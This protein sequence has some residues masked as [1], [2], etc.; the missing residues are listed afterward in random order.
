LKGFNQQ[1]CNANNFTHFFDGQNYFNCYTFNSIR[2]S[3]KILIHATG[4]EYGLSAVIALDNDDPPLIP[5][6]FVVHQILNTVEISPNQQPWK[7]FF[8]FVVLF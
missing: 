4:P 2:H 5:F 3:E 1:K 7:Y 6:L 8:P